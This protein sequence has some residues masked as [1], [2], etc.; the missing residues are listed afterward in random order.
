MKLIIKIIVLLL[1]FSCKNSKEGVVKKFYYPREASFLKKENYEVLN[2]KSFKNFEDLI[3]SLQGLNYY[4]K[5]AYIKVEKNKQEYN[6][7]VSTTFGKGMPPFLKFKNILSIS[8]DS[9]LKEKKYSIG[10]L[11]SVLKKDLL[12]YGKDDR[13]SDSPEKLVVSLTCKIDE[14]ESLL[15]KVVTMFNEI[16]EHSSDSLK[17]NIFLNRRIEIFPPPPI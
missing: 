13:Y 15:M 8:K 11:I 1:F 4:D 12:N 10:D 17:L 5:K 2:F 6:I 9:I 14:L 7:L 16:K 3:D